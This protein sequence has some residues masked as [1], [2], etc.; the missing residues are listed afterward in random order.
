MDGDADWQQPTNLSVEKGDQPCGTTAAAVKDG[1]RPHEEHCIICLEVISERAV[2]VPC[3]HLSF[4]F[5]CLVS[6][7]QEKAACPLCKAE[8]REVQYDWRSSEDFKTYRVPEAERSKAEDPDTSAWRH[9][10]RQAGRRRVERWTPQT[11]R[12]VPPSEDP[13]LE[14][15]RRVYRDRLYA[16]HVGANQISNYRDFT[17]A[18]FAS[19]PVLQSRA[20]AFLRRELRV[21][22]FLDT[23]SAPRGGNREFLLEYIVA[24]LRTNDLKAAD[25]KAED[26]L[27]DFLGRSNAQQLLHE[28][29]AWLRSP[30]V[31]LRQWDEAVQ[32]FEQNVGGARSNGSNN[33]HRVGSP[34]TE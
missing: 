27:S 2:A 24:I 28:L 7:L 1:K 26:L 5:L 31:D 20:R 32:Y 22:S 8:V 29:E 11:E 33:K 15:R 21:F 16:L 23:P 6:W 10:R 34:V 25:G 12:T 17:S 4:D 19:S 13:S 9:S 3:N 14:R 18:I 30:Y